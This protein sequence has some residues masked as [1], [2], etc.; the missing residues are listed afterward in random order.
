MLY[1]VYGDTAALRSNYPAMKKW[2]DYM[3]GF[4]EDGIMPKN[5]YGDWCVPP[6]SPELIHS[7]DPGRQTRGALLSTAFFYHDLTLM[8]RA[9]E[10]LEESADAARFRTLAET[11]KAAF[12]AKYFDMARGYYDNG[13]QTSC[14]LPLAF[15]M[16]PPEERARVFDHLVRKIE[17]ESRGHIGTGLVGGQWLMRV[18]SDNGRA[19]LAYRIASQK[20]YPGWGYM[21]LEGGDDDLGALERR[22]RRPGHQLGQ[23]SHAG[24]RPGH[25]DARL[26]RGHPAR[27]RRS[28]LQ[29][30]HH[31]PYAR[32]RPDVGPGT[33]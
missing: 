19:D 15:G 31:P 11:I 28:R 29:E 6:E 26:S 10:L 8:V 1:D 4:L 27:P 2:I 20:D 5:T 12:Q 32:R 23:P 7:K 14:V 25:L 16:V 24:G 17:G 33:L 9:A 21:V 22:H 3:A 18:L 30:D 13:T